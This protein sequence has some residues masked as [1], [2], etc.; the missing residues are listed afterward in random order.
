MLMVMAL[1]Y[2]ISP[3]DFI[4]DIF[5][6]LGWL[7]DIGVLSYAGKNLSKAMKGPISPA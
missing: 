2:T 4:P 7:D 6:V 3:I 1:L 5:P